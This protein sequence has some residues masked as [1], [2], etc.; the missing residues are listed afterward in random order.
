MA[1]ST[2]IDV[3]KNCVSSKSCRTLS[4]IE[5]YVLLTAMLIVFLTSS[6]LGGV[7]ATVRCSNI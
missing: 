2:V 3:L 4:V 7:V 6:D 5:V 1:N